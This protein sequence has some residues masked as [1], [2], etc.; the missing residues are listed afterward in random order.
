MS[1]TAPAGR[2]APLW[3][4]LPVKDFGRAKSRLTSVLSA[5]ARYALARRLCEHAL[6]TLRDSAAIDG[7]LVIS[8]SDAVLTLA[9]QLGATGVRETA[10]AAPRVLG[11]IVDE[12]LEILARRGAQA[13]LVLMSD[14]PQL[15]PAELAQLLSYL[16]A[17]DY[18]VAPDRREQN[19]NALALRLAGRAPTAFGSGDSFRQHTELLAAAG[20]RVAIHRA[21][22]LA[23]DVDV[24]E[25]YVL[26]ER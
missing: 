23:F 15:H 22:G 2:P 19:T 25:D 4:L 20:R 6:Q 18:V 1:A 13:A 8:D 16:P 24:P 17:H 7:V 11:A 21:P 3:A 12:G 14:L 26:L 5:T 10:S 9:Q